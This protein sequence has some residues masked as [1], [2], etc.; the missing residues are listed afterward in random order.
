MGDGNS[1]LLN[2]KIYFKKLKYNSIY[3]SLN[4]KPWN[5]EIL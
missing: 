4:F 2:N 5:E 3:K 1:R